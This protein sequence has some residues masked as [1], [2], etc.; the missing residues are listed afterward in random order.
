MQWSVRVLLSNPPLP[1]KRTFQCLLG[2][3]VLTFG[4]L[5]AWEGVA[6]AAVVYLKMKGRPSKY[7]QVPY[8]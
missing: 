7:S 8:I 4:H 2:D 3:E 1:P 6:L 5:C